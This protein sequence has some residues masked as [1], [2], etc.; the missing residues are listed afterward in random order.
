MREESKVTNGRKDLKIIN[1]DFRW[2]GK[3]ESCLHYQVCTFVTAQ[4]NMLHHV[5]EYR[6]AKKLKRISNICTVHLILNQK[7][8]YLVTYM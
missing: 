4:L 1:T 7:K 2:I 8:S 3:V 5:R 6:Y